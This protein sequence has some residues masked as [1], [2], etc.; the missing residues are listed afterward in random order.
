MKKKHNVVMLPTNEAS[1]LQLS[2]NGLRFTSNN[3]WQS[4]HL[5]FTSDE[6]IK[7]GD[8]LIANNQVRQILNGSFDKVS[9]NGDDVCKKII[10]TT[11]LSLHESTEARG[12]EFHIPLSEIPQS[13]IQEYVKAEGKIDEVMLEWDLHDKDIYCDNWIL[14][15]N[16]NEVIWSLVEGQLLNTLTPQQQVERERDEDFSDFPLKVKECIHPF[17][18]IHWVNDVVYCNE[19]NTTLNKTIEEKMYSMEEVIKIIDDFT[20]AIHCSTITQEQWIEENL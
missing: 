15:L 10:A 14:K 2:P 8:W 3:S 19:C 17:N 1:G 9:E 20:T 13:F 11:D 18:R 4:Q 7:D 6:D 12:K 16:N 5:Y